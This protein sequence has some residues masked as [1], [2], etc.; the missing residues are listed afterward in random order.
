MSSWLIDKSALVRLGASPDA[1]L[2]ANRLERGLVAITTVTRLEVGYSYSARSSSDLG[3]IMDSPHLVNAGGD[4]TPAIKDRALQLQ[5]LL[6]ERGHHRGASIPDL[7][8]AAR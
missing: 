6:S 1:Q 8:V 5:R 4:S 7:I 2:W 3:Q